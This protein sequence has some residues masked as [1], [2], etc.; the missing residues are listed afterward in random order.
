M[1]K[2]LIIVEGMDNT[3]KDTL[4]SGIKKSLTYGTFDEQHFTGPSKY[5]DSTCAFIEQVN[6]FVD[7]TNKLATLQDDLTIW[8][9]SHIGEYVYGQVYRNIDK[10][11]IIKLI[12]L[13]D[14]LLLSLDIDIVYVQLI[15]KSNELMIKNEDGKSLSK[16]IKDKEKYIN[17]IN[18]ERNLFMDAYN[19]VSDKFKKIMIVVN[20]GDEFISKKEILDKVIRKIYE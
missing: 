17:A 5:K 3:G 18:N 2:T 12:N 9:R 11:I 10:K 16:S 7:K 14:E 6:Q 20:D 4:I 19:V 13:I 1:K 8:N 15:C